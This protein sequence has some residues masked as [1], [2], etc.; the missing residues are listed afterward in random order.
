MAKGA[1]LIEEKGRRERERDRRDGVQLQ[2]H[3]TDFY[4]EIR[5]YYPPHPDRGSFPRQTR[6]ENPVVRIITELS[7]YI[8]RQQIQIVRNAPSFLSYC[9]PC[10]LVLRITVYVCS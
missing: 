4:R 2:T 1:G 7:Q 10:L 6:R 3:Q 8:A 9:R 5:R